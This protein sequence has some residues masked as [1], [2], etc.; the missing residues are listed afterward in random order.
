MTLEGALGA[1]IY[2]LEDAVQARVLFGPAKHGQIPD[3]KSPREFARD[4]IDD[5][6]NSEF[7]EVL[8]IAMQ[9][10]RNRNLGA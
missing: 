9:D 7:L 3:N 8:T 6:S 10:L 1:P 4:A 5:L 2:D